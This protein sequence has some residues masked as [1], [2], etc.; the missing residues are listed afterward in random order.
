VAVVLIGGGARCGKSRFALEY[1]EQRF[2]RRLFLA[3][4]EALDDEMAG[5]IE[6]HRRER[7]P[8]WE[9][10]EEPRGLIASL[11]KSVAA[12]DV[13][14]VDCLTLWLSNVMLAESSDARQEVARLEEYL[15]KPRESTLIF[16]TNEVGCGI[17]PDSPLAR[18]YRDLA[19]EMNQAVGRRAD[20]IYWMV[21]GAP[22]LVKGNVA[23][24]GR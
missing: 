23:A 16:V 19:G 8:G 10:I 11:E 17:V 2:A 15:G 1:A 13:C 21:F 12:F 7:R 18:A 3:T 9:T 24:M 5:R 20:E 22:L 4:A 14:V 6:R